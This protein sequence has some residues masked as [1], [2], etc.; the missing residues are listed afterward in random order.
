MSIENLAREL[1]ALRQAAQKLLDNGDIDGWIK[2]MPAEFRAAERLRTQLLVHPVAVT[3]DPTV[4][5]PLAAIDLAELDDTDKVGMQLLWGKI[6][7]AEYV[8]NLALV[9]VLIAPS[10]IPSNLRQ[11]IGEA[12]ECYAIG[13]NAA[14]QSLSRTILE[15]AVNDIAVRTRR[16]PV[17]A[18]ERDMFVKYPPRERIRLV[19]GNYYEQIYQHYRDL[20][21]VVHGLT[22]TIVEGP[23]GSLTKTIGY[24]QH[25]YEINKNSVGH[26]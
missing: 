16:I 5:E 20:C 23:L 10:D 2:A 13:H 24:V 21:K 18:I 8:A 19:S 11:F 3:D 12:R 15:A 6:S 4:K 17:E 26:A 1:I 9:D 14:V 7:P 22:T 25:L